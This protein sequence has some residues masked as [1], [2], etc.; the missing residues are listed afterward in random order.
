MKPL[1]EEFGD[2]LAR[3]VREG[4][5]YAEA[6]RRLI[7][8]EE[9]LR[10][11]RPSYWVVRDFMRREQELRAV[12]RKEAAERRDQWAAVAEQLAKGRLPNPY[13]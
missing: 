13:R 1:D 10:R 3:C 12:E 5:S 8:V 6:W 2:E 7:P 4:V 11:R 9:R